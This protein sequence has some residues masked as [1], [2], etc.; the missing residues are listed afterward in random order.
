MLNVLSGFSKKSVATAA[1]L[2]LGAGAL[3][4]V[5]VRADDA[6]SDAGKMSVMSNEDH[7][8]MMSDL[9]KMRASAADPQQAEKLK[10]HMAKMMTM[11]NMAKKM[12]SDTACKQACADA[13]NDA[14]IKRLHEEAEQMAADP[15]EMAKLQKEISSD[16]VLM[17]VVTHRALML[18]MMP[19]A[20]GQTKDMNDK[21]KDMGDKM[22]DMGGKLLN[23]N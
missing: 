6:P 10:I 3:F 13:L 21:M 9:A 2:A 18:S 5:H 11:D 23:K 7:Q 16:P 15:A 20:T 22:K 4:T 14:N 8:M 12:A 1:V 17:K 19:V